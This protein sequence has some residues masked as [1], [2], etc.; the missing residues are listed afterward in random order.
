MNIN[1]EYINTFEKRNKV[2][3]TQWSIIYEGIEEAY[4]EKFDIFQMIL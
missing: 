4:S 2:Y 1:I 3:T